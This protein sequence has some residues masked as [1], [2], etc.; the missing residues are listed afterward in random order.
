[1]TPQDELHR[2]SDQDADLVLHGEPS[3]LILRYCVTAV[4]LGSLVLVLALGVIA[5]EQPERAISAAAVFLIGLLAWLLLRRGHVQVA[6]YGLVVGLWASVTGIVVFTGGVRAPLVILYPAMILVVGWLVSARAAVLVA[7]AT[8]TCTLLLL[9]IEAWGWLPSA[10]PSSSLM[11][12]GD[13]VIVYALT[14]L[15]TYLLVRTF[16]GRLKELRRISRVL[17]LRTLDLEARQ[18]ELKLPQGARNSVEP[19]SHAD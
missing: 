3:L 13:Q 17:T 15:L 12:G 5:P 9:G 1:M 10:L 6:T 16:M 19:E 18:A 14:A 4:M 8:V 11:Y 2:R 7:G